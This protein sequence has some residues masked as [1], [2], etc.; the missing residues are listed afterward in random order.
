MRRVF[1]ALGR[2]MREVPPE[3]KALIDNLAAGEAARM[4]VEK[5]GQRA[6]AGN[7]EA[8]TDNAGFLFSAAK[9]E[10]QGTIA[11][12]EEEMSRFER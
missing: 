10:R 2:A 4:E 6:E 12:A 5:P 7:A 8:D 11:A 3:L 1:E 9:G